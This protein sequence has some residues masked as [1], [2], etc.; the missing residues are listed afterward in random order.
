[1]GTSMTE[2]VLQ[3]WGDSPVESQYLK[4]WDIEAHDGRGDATF[5]ADIKEAHGFK[6][7][8]EA[9]ETWRSQS[10]KRPFRDDGKPNRPLTAFSVTLETRD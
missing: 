8:S 7:L 4:S 2:T 5:T 3:V 9:M 6:N 1:M 10:V